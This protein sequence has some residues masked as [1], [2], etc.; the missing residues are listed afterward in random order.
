MELYNSAERRAGDE[1]VADKIKYE[2]KPMLKLFYKSDVN[3][4]FSKTQENLSL[5]LR[6]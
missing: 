3:C 6:I 4:C 2:K 5:A 1:V